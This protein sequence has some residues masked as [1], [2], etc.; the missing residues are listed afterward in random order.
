MVQTVAI[1]GT[2]TI[3]FKRISK[4]APKG[5]RL[6]NVARTLR[7]VLPL[8]TAAPVLA[9][10]WFTM[11]ENFL[12]FM[13]ASFV[14]S[15][16]VTQDTFSVYNNARLASRL[17]TVANSLCMLLSFTIAWLRLNPA[18][19]TLSIVAVTLVPYVIKRYNF[20]R[21]T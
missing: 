18:W 13:L 17:N 20:Y 6:M 8:L 14:A 3:L 15:V 4:S 7:M 16:F 21:E 1:F 10:V 12:A 9:W 19:F 11:P 5:L 2:E